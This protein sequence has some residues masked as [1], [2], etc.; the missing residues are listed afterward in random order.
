M[1]LY[2]NIFKTGGDLFMCYNCGCGLPEDDMGKGALH[3]DGG[4]LVEEDFDQMAEKWGMDKKEAKQN[5]LDLLQKEL[6]K[7]D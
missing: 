6:A 1:L 7:E 4:S 3:K 2:A 5:V